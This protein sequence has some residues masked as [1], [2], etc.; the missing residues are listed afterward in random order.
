[1]ASADYENMEEEENWNNEENCEMED[2]Y[3]EGGGG[4]GGYSDG[5][6]EGNYEEMGEEGDENFRPASKIGRGAGNF[7]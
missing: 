1:M 5:E 3:G 2:E 4:G 6:A 7:R